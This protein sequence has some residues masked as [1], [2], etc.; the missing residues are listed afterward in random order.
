M[1]LRELNTEIDLVIRSFFVGFKSVIDIG[2]SSKCAKYADLF[3]LKNAPLI[4][5][6]Q[7]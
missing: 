1:S 4:G 5:Y 6:N 2:E 3:F 7:K